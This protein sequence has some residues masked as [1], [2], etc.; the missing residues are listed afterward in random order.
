MTSENKRT[1]ARAAAGWI[2]KHPRTSI[3]TPAASAVVLLV[4]Y[5]LCLAVLAT[6]ALC[7]IVWRFA[8]QP[9]FDRFCWR[10]AR[11][12]YVRW[13][14][15]QRKWERIAARCGLSVTDPFN[16]KVYVP[17]IK[18]VRS[19]LCWDSIIVRSEEGQE[20]EDFLAASEKIRSA[21][22]VQRVALR[23]LE[24]GK[25]SIDLQRSE[26]FHRMPVPATPMPRTAAEVN[27][28]KIPVGRTEYGAIWTIS[29]LDSHLV[30]AG[31]T[32]AGKSSLPWNV[33]RGVAP[34]IADGSVRLYGV[35]PKGIELNMAKSIFEKHSVEDGETVELVKELKNRMLERK[36]LLQDGRARQFTASPET[37]LEVLYVDEFAAPFAYAPR[38]MRDEFEDALGLLLTQGRAF[39][40]YVF[41]GLQEPTKDKLP[42]RDLFPRRLAMRLPSKSYVEAIL[43]DDAIDVSGAHAHKIS[44]LLPGVGYVMD[45]G[46]SLASRVRAGWVDDRDID[47]LVKH[48]EACR[49]V[50]DLDARRQQNHD[51]LADENAA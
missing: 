35:D 49:N 12:W 43:G 1:P 2:G 7:G 20:L 30:Y 42:V 13:W 22:R 33:F 25:I 28:R 46:K 36:K 41:G 29:L 11:A 19:T 45:E 10:F 44:E 39:G 47:A 40:F 8:D 34:L 3:T 4:G 9:T 16:G 6:A 26:P 5:Q 32:G 18:R 15:Y 50:I 31:A 51:G 37:P 24:P 23:E 27:L 48:I 14:I 38:K 17:K 21:Y